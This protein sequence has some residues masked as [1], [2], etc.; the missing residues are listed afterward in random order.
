MSDGPVLA[1]AADHLSQLPVASD[2]VRNGAHTVGLHSTECVEPVVWGG[3][4]SIQDSRTP[5]PVLNV[6]QPHRESGSL[7]GRHRSQVFPGLPSCAALDAGPFLAG[8]E[9]SFFPFHGCSS[10]TQPNPILAPQTL[11]HR[12]ERVGRTRSRAF[13]IPPNTACWSSQSGG[14]VTS[15]L[16]KMQFQRP[17]CFAE[18]GSLRP[19]L[20]DPQLKLAP[21]WLG[22]SL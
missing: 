20:N 5:Q 15:A 17:G 2:R 21:D 12:R 6:F 16:C 4:H 1:R 10:P 22:A 13:V 7:P 11:A 18:S 9:F 3:A 19:D 14:L 8:F